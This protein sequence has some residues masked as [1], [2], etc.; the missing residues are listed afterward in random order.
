MNVCVLRPGDLTS[1]QLEVWS[2]IQ[3]T[4]PL[5][6]SPFFRPEFTLA[7]AAV[8]ADVEVAVL[9]ENGATVGFFPFQRGGRVGR[10]AGGP[11]SDYQ[12]VIIRAGKRWEATEMIRACGLLAW[13]FDHLLAAQNEFAAFH[14]RIDP[15]P[16][17]ELKDGFDAYRSSLGEANLKYLNATFRQARQMGREV[18]P[19]RV[20]LASTDRDALRLL[21]RWKSE[22][23]ARS[24]GVDLFAFAWTRALLETLLKTQSES[25]S[26]M[27]SLLFAGERLV[28]A[29][30]GPSAHG[31][32]HWWFPAYD[33]QFAKYSPGRILLAEVARGAQAHGIRRIDLGRGIDDYKQRAM[34]GSTLVAS[35]AVDL[36]PM[37]RWLSDQWSRTRERIKKSPLRGVA[38]VPGRLVYRLTRWLSLR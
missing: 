30:M 26:G 38:R 5:F 13:R 23:Y 12:G 35:G 4:E 27:L 7:L 21:M 10:P 34:S 8:R 18:G 9:E 1:A 22:Q 6:E 32:L 3:R 25:F 36:R 15:S 28:S 33:R 31:V 17:L 29:H 20:E 24:G 16:Y 37:T 14:R 11:L 19:V 2:E